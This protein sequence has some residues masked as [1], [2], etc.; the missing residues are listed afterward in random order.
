MFLTTYT[1]F[2]VISLGNHTHTPQKKKK[3]YFGLDYVLHNYNLHLHLGR[4][5]AVT[6]PS[7]LLE[8][9]EEDR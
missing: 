7:I 2:N 9:H 5:V 8:G 1:T 3:N 6:A 4:G